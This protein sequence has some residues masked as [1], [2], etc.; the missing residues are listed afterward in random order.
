MQPFPKQS[1]YLRSP[2][3]KLLCNSI[4]GPRTKKFVDHWFKLYRLPNL[5]K[6]LIFVDCMN[7]LIF[8]FVRLQQFD[9]IKQGLLL[10]KNI[11]YSEWKR[12][13]VIFLLHLSQTLVWNSSTLEVS[14]SFSFGKQCKNV[15]CY[16]ANMPV[17]YSFL[18]FSLFFCKFVYSACFSV[19]P[20]NLP[21]DHL[22]LPVHRQAFHPL[23]FL[24]L[25]D[26]VLLNNF[27]V[28]FK[29]LHFVTYSFLFAWNTFK[30]SIDL[31]QQ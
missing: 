8:T 17:D 29:L 25:A 13:W 7:T 6:P 14:S 9:I 15:F 16:V 4:R 2:A 28:P 30:F 23:V 11:I 5:C 18:C 22:S 27:C 31:C 20:I 10:H 1:H 24:F 21:S 19:V 12:L 26:V 3:L